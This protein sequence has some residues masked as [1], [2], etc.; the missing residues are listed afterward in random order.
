ML[1]GYEQKLIHEVSFECNSSSISTARPV[2]IIFQFEKQSGSPINN[3]Y[4]ANSKKG[5]FSSF[6]AINP[7]TEIQ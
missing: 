6:V 5:F 1:L 3:A 4:K 7:K 2:F